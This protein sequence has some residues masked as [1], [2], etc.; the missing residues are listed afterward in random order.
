[1][2]RKPPSVLA[3]RV[4]SGNPARL[5]LDQ[6]VPRV[7][8][9]LDPA[10]RLE[11]VPVKI[12]RPPSSTDRWPVDNHGRHRQFIAIDPRIDH[13]PQLFRPLRLLRRHQITFHVIVD[14]LA[15]AAIRFELMR[16]LSLHVER[17]D[18]ERRDRL[19]ARLHGR[20]EPGGPAAGWSRRRRRR[21]ER[22]SSTLAGRRL[23]VRPLP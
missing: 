1:M 2:R 18:D 5:L 4:K 7:R 14:H 22:R 21:S 17:I 16:K 23:A 13:A 12:E 20:G 19:D 3:T 9:I 10:R 6:V 11:I 8:N 15:I